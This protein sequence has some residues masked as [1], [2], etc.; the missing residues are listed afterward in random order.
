MKTRNLSRVRN[1]GFVAH[2]DAGKT[3]VTERVLYYTGKIHRMGEVHD[4][5]ATM[6]WMPQEQERGITITSAVTTCE[7][8]NH[9][10]HII[11]T[12]GHVD[13]T[14]EVERSLR[15]LDGA[16][17]ILCAVGGVEA[18]TETVWQQ[19]RKYH[20]P[21]MAFI[22]KLDRMGADFNSVLDQIRH[23]LEVKPLPIQIP[24]YEKDTFKGVIDLISMQR[25][26]WD[27]D[28]LGANVVVSPVPEDIIQEAF[29][30][31]EYMLEVLA[32]HDDEIMEK[33]LSGEQPDQKKIKQAVRKVTV[34]EKAVP[35][36]C[37]SALK[38]KGI[39]TLID[40]IIDY[41]PS[42][43]EVRPV[44][45]HAKKTGQEVLVHPDPK[46]PLVAYVFKVYMDEGRRMV[47]LRLYSG[48]LT[49]GEEVFNST[50][51]ISEK[52]ARLFAMHAHQKQRIEQASAGD[53]VA[54]VG[55]KDSI[56]GDTIM[57]EGETIVLE[58]IEIQKPVISVAIEPKTSE[59]SERL[60]EAMRKIME[61][62]P[63]IKV[64]EDQDTG[65]VILAGMGELHLEIALDRF[66]T[67]FGVEINVGKPQV[68]YCASID[69]PAQT[70][71]IF[72]KLIGETP[73]YG[74]VELNVKPAKR[75]RGNSFHLD[76]ALENGLKGYVM[77]GLEEAC[78]ADPLFGY[79]V[80][81][82]DVHVEKVVLNDKTTGQGLKIATQMA[83]QEAMKKSGVIQLEP[84]MELDAL[85]PED[86][87]GDVVGD[88]SA[89]K[90]S[91]EGVVTK[92]KYHQIKAYVPLSN[93]FGYS[94][95]LRSLTRGRGSF[96]MRFHGFDKV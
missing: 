34:E 84:I 76:Q 70:G 5:Q 77:N 90:A 60:L 30:A 2:I 81:D 89:R 69:K 9:D 63:T 25:L 71:K 26:T 64:H 19:S 59:S 55:L 28:A 43:L 37:G 83:L 1:I 15:V 95:V 35:V 78:L 51:E 74:H 17:V 3:T 7:W 27:D 65:Q 48:T 39:Q 54:A 62:D 79:E 21:A 42:P 61:E 38:N 4:G 93:T 96:S 85:S 11:D 49:V 94:T 24:Y 29:A 33:F 20:V 32:D 58:A 16:V 14:I 66:K 72:E 88:L 57:L 22:N 13:F 47:Y 50:R 53:I 18:Q 45:A 52:V 87:V 82:I 36:L 23:R 10:I 31:R 40:A 80:V 86:Y 12:P 46:G 92:G 8:N 67:A 68:L 91:I 73:H 6:D 56:T 75:G 44:M 41:L